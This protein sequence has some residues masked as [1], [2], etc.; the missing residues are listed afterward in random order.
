MAITRY[1]KW[2]LGLLLA[3]ACGLL[4]AAAGLVDSMSLKSFCVVL[5]L[6]IYTNVK[7]YLTGNP[8]E[9]ISDTSFTTNPQSSQARPPAAPLLLLLALVA[10][11]GCARFH[12]E[13]LQ[14]K[15][16]GTRLESRQTILTFW[17]GQANVAKLRASTTEKTQGLTV[18][19]F[20]EEASSTNAVDLINGIVGA[21]VRAAVKP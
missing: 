11:C 14:T 17:D 6:A 18:G 20:S 2:R 9:D 4:N 16:D 15:A 1:K 3:I 7:N 5:A 10:L 8:I 13:Q 12:S 21:A 19:S